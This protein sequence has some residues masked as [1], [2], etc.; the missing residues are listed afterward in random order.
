MRLFK[1]F[2][3]NRLSI[4]QTRLIRFSQPSAFN[5]PFEFL[6]NIDSID[7]PGNVTETFRRTME[8]QFS[9]EYDALDSFAK[10]QVSK[11]QFRTL[12]QSYLLMA[13]QQS[14][15]IFSQLALHAQEKIHQVSSQHMGVLCLSERHDDLLMWAHY[16]DCH[17][18]F[19]LEFDSDSPFFHQSRSEQDSLRHL[20]AVLYRKERPAITLA[21]TDMSELFLTKSE[22][23]AYEKEW[24]MIVGLAD[25]DK[26]VSEGNEDVCLFEFPAEAIRSVFFGARMNEDVSAALVENIKNDRSLRHLNVFKA[27]VHSTNY[28]L[29]F[30]AV[31][32]E[33]TTEL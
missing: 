25:A 26:V 11:E 31:E 5:D 8:S 19:V 12:M 10:S 13:E 21:D 23:W 15:S 20:E 33:K 27:K 22:H 16:A 32:T 17:K 14:G 30:E 1:Y 2:G 18:G 24:R 6:P 4:L 3:P 7:T 29:V 28:D 9:N